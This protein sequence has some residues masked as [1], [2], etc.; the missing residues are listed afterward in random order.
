MFDRIGHF[1]VGF[2]ALPIM[3]YVWSRGIIKSK[4][5][6]VLYGIFAIAFVAAC[7]EWIE[8]IYAVKYGGEA[9]AVFLGS[10]GDVWDA[11]MDVLMD[12][13]GGE[14]EIGFGLTSVTVIIYTINQFR[15]L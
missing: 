2:Y 6:T 9:G 8:W 12:V 5:V 15:D 7:Y 14:R 1:A 4:L 11:E 3:E 13:L 10:Q